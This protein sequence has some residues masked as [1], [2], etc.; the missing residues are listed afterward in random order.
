MNSVLLIVAS[1]SIVACCIALVAYG[2]GRWGK[3]PAL[4]HLMWIAVFVK[5]I[6]PPLIVA[7]VTV[8]S[9][10][11]SSFGSVYRVLNIEP[12]DRLANAMTEQPLS[13][14]AEAEV[15]QVHALNTPPSFI[16]KIVQEV[17]WT[18]IWVG[19]WLLGTTL[20]FAR[21]ILRFTQ[22]SR[23][24][25]RESVVDGE[26][27]AVVQRLV[28]GRRRFTPAVRRI[29][30][31]VSPMLFG[32]GRATCIVCPDRLWEQLSEGQREAFLAHEVAHFMRRDH[33]LRWLEWFV[34]A[35]Y[36]WF[37]LVYVARRQLERHEEAA[38][39]AWAVVR[40]NAS[41]RVYAE[42]LLNVVDFLSE[43]RVGIPRLASRMQ[44]TDSLEE[45]LRLIMSAG[46]ES[47][48]SKGRRSL[49]VVAC[50]TLLI[51]HPIPSSVAAAVAKSTSLLE[52]S[53]VVNDAVQSDLEIHPSKIS[54]SAISLPPVPQGWWNEPPA[55]TWAE[56]KIAESDMKLLA[57]AGI[58]ISLSKNNQ[59]QHVF[60]SQTV[61]AIAHVATSGRLILGDA[62]GDL[63]LWDVDASQ[64]VS[65]IGRHPA[66]VTSVAY[67]P[68]S[69]LVSSDAT[70]NVFAWDIQ[71]GR[72]KGAVSVD[73]NVCSLRWTTTGNK[74]A[75]VVSN[76]ADATASAKVLIVNS[77]TLAT[78]QL[79]HIPRDVAIAQQHK[80]KGW[81]AVDWSGTLWSLVTGNA[82]GNIPKE[83]VS[84]I[85][86]CQDVFDHVEVLATRPKMEN[87]NE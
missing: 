54:S 9:S 32:A 61:R 63:H 26:A 44:G 64:A 74:L 24:L 46:K 29:G 60:N 58:G 83:C 10:M 4:A 1:N 8:P 20:I 53:D 13:G 25:V 2:V 6:T 52:S 75:I 56:A 36:W 16:A 86:L 41:R 27:S 71:S 23:L 80:S 70:G 59:S 14:T 39:D 76:W 3:S 30:A 49:L 22:F 19:V 55:R 57:E 28:D 31:R 43:N 7:P 37:P 47:G 38:C 12:R 68:I 79:L 69:G 84:G 72:I 62:N 67:H 21:G 33:W 85:V 5:L 18:R 73:G 48:M 11:G 17:T 35:V 65:L 51:I 78:E 34:T 82:V 81:V 50:L 87:E 45:R 15:I 77:S 40:L 42:T 66:S